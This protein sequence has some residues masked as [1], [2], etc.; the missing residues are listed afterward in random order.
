MRP[1]YVSFR[2]CSQPQFDRLSHV[3]SELRRDKESG[4]FRPDEDWKVYFAAD[5]LKSFWNPTE[6]ERADWQRR[7]LATPVP[8]RFSDPS[9]QTAWDFG[10]M[11]EAIREGEYALLGV[12]SDDLGTGLLEF[13]PAAYPF[14]GT[15]CLRALVA[16]YGHP[17]IGYDDGTG[18]IETES[19]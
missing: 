10:S 7:W 2:I 13:E 16:A 3:V 4:E 12:R 9:L 17:L 19:T 1:C 11:L 14:G 18:F 8:D 15:G 5:E 6:E